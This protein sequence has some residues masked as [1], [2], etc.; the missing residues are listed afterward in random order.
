LRTNHKISGAVS[1]QFHLFLLIDTVSAPPLP[2]DI[3]S[4]I[5]PPICAAASRR[6]VDTAVACITL[7]DIHHLNFRIS[8]YR[9]R[10]CHYNLPKEHAPRRIEFPEAVAAL[11]LKLW[12]IA[13]PP[14]TALRGIT[15]G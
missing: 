3:A 9:L 14:K 2:P 13:F 4:N 1:D 12:L 10:A 6:V 15:T 7:H 5:L 11:N 8:P